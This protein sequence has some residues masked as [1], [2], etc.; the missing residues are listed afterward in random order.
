MRITYVYAY[1]NGIS[2][3]M[4]TELH[5][6]LVFATEATKLWCSI[7]ASRLRPWDAMGIGNVSRSKLPHVPFVIPSRC[8]F[9]ELTKTIQLGDVFYHSLQ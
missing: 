1:R 7:A 9:V 8:Q 6:H 4:E 2:R 5:N 3:P